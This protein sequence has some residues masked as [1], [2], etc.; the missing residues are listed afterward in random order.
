MTDIKRLREKRLRE[1]LIERILDGVGTASRGWRRAAFENA[2]L[3]EPLRT[4]VQKVATQAVAVTDRDIAAARE[5]GVTEDQIFE[6]VVCAA[7]GQSARQYESA[8]AALGS[9]LAKE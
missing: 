8:G 7:V 5:S 6:I 1:A 4:L 3:A 2:G 9:A